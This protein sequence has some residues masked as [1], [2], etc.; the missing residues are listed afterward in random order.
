[1]FCFRWNKNDTRDTFYPTWVFL[2]K[3]VHPSA[4]QMDMIATEDIDSFVTDSFNENLTNYVL[5]I[6]DN[7]LDIIGLFIMY[8]YP[9]TKQNVKTYLHINEWKK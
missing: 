4:K 8:K 3:H 9:I 5:E 7:I 2:N 1:M 6:A